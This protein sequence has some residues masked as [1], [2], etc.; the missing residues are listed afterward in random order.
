MV[1]RFCDFGK[2]RTRSCIFSIAAASMTVVAVAL[3]C[4]AAPSAAPGNPLVSC[5]QTVLALSRTEQDPKIDGILEDGEWKDAVKVELSYQVYP[6]ENLPA[7][8]RTE[9]FLAYSR[10]YLFV[11]FHAFAHRADSIRARV[12]RRDDVFKDDFVAIYLDTYHDRQRAYS[13]F[14]NPLGI[15]ADG[16]LTNTASA[17]NSAQM[18]QDV[19]LSWDGVL[20][21]KGIAAND[22]YVVEAAIPFRTLRFQVGQDHPW[23]LHLQRWIAHKAERDSWERVSLNVSGLLAQMGQM[24]GLDDLFQGKTLDLIPTVTGVIAG[25][26]Q[27]DGRMNTNYLGS[28]GLSFGLGLSPNFTVSGAINPDFSQVESD[29][30]Q[31]AVNQRFPLFFPEKRPFFLEGAELFQ[32]IVPSSGTIQFVDTRQIVDPAWGAKISGKFG[33]TSLGLLSANDQAPGLRISPG[34]AGY[35][36]GTAINI[37]RIKQ[38]FLKDSAVGLTVTDWRFSD[39]SNTVAAIDGQIRFRNVNSFGFAGVFTHTHDP[40]VNGPGAAYILRLNRDGRHLKYNFNDR[41]ITDDYRAFLGFTRTTGIHMDSLSVEYH[42]RPAKS[43]WLVDIAPYTEGNY[44]RTT[45]GVVQDAWFDQGAIMQ[46]K[47]NIHLTLVN[48]FDRAGFAGKNLP[49]H[50]NSVFFNA[51]AI[52]PFSINGYVTVGTW[53]YFD[54]ANAV[55]GKYVELKTDAVFKPSSRLEL[56]ML[57]LK[58]TLNDKETARRIFNQEII[59]NRVVFQFTRSTFVRS[60]LEYDTL[61]RSISVS[62]LFAYTPRPNTALYVGYGDLLYNGFD[63]IAQTRSPGLFRLRRSFFVKVSYNYRYLFNRRGNARNSRQGASGN[64]FSFD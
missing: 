21:S 64:A 45:K 36:Q 15:Q 2:A 3:V 55:V 14:F 27:N 13:F 53:P 61:N 33:R 22:G 1:Q 43:A 16:F 38:D 39:S 4:H 19:D 47:R 6:G 54:P 42:L 20:E 49:Y 25:E 31:I 34:E 58:S 40:N 28:P 48:S 59:R 63:P 26:R 52:K 41:H 51:Q 46:L 12:T 8:E 24:D 17:I 56:G 9:V 10:E 5:K 23:G 29:V 18:E 44:E 57:Y 37:V 30:P 7:S 62:E 32:M 11:A 50:F 60:I 35:K